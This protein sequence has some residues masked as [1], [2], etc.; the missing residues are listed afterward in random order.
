MRLAQEIDCHSNVTANQLEAVTCHTNL[1]G[2]AV[3][4]G[5]GG[6]QLLEF[7]DSH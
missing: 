6:F 3:A 7:S 1:G 2:E 5:R 4:V